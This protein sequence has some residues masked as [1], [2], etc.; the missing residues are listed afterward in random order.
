M[1]DHHHHSLRNLFELAVVLSNLSLGWVQFLEM[2]VELEVGSARRVFP[3][4]RGAVGRVVGLKHL[5][6]DAALRDGAP[7]RREARDAD[8]T[9]NQRV[10][11]DGDIRAV[12]VLA[13]SET[14]GVGP[15]PAEVH[16]QAPVRLDGFRPEPELGVVTAAAAREAA[17]DLE[18]HLS[19]AAKR[20]VCKR[21]VCAG[22]FR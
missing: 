22:S 20:V 12:V 15:A 13:E 11:H 2:V 19:G 4:P 16:E 10:T 9:K 17:E 18:V 7:P 21:V 8:A 1:G 14:V 5:E 6:R 3:T